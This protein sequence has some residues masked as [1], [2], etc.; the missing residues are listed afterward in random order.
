M[1]E[2]LGE[3]LHDIDQALVRLGTDEDAATEAAD[4]A[5]KAERRLER[6][7]YQGMAGLLDVE[8]RGERIARRELYRRCA[9]IGDMVIDVAE[10][11][12]YAVVK[13]S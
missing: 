10:R 5:I 2:L 3:A 9:R 8:S 12:V 4:A 6:A 7:Y 11:I 1:A 13:Q